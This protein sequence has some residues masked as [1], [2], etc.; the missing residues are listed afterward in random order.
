MSGRTLRERKDFAG[1]TMLRREV[2]GRGGRGDGRGG[3]IE[4]QEATKIFRGE[5]A[6]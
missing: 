1:S 3:V 4:S 6:V 5:K 2:K